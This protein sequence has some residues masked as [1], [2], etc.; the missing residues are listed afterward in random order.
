MLFMG[1]VVGG[2]VGG[3]FKIGLDEDEGDE[4][5]RNGQVFEGDAFHG[6]IGELFTVHNPPLPMDW[7]R[8]PVYQATR[9]PTRY[10]LAARKDAV[11]RL[12]LFEARR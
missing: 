2:E 9:P 5:G 7:G 6:L 1:L 10:G 8:G 4:Q 3:R 11:S 12:Q